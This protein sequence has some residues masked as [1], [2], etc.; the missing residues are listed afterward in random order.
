MQ[1]LWYWGPVAAYAGV[2]F[3][4]SSLSF[5]PAELSSLVEELSDK[6]L[7]FCEYAVLGV[8]LYRACRHAA[9]P[10]VSRSALTYAIVGSVLYG[11][12]DELHQSFVP[13]REA[14]VLDALADAVGATFGGWSWRLVGR[15]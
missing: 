9:G 1:A 3:Y 7:H 10:N 11:L 2:I 5:M 8:L 4:F 12:S 13:L 15:A 14:D 6:I